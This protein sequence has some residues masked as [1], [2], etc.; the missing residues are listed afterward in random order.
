MFAQQHEADMI[1]FASFAWMTVIPPEDSRRLSAALKEK[2]LK[3]IEATHDLIRELGIDLVPSRIEVCSVAAASPSG[4]ALA[5]A[6]VKRTPKGK[7]RVVFNLEQ[8]LSHDPED[9]GGLQVVHD[10]VPV[11]EGM[12]IG[13][14]V[15]EALQAALGLVQTTK[16]DW[17]KG[18]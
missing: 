13:G 14:G 5:L 6:K 17:R 8:E 1:A 16:A 15:P 12:H 3:P 7:P 18:E 2:G 11:L 4:K 9:L 10:D